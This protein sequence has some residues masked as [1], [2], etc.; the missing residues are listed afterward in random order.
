[1]ILFQNQIFQTLSIQQQQKPPD[2]NPPPPPL[3]PPPSP[4]LPSLLLLILPS[5][6]SLSAPPIFSSRCTACNNLKV[7]TCL[8]LTLVMFD[9]PAGT[10]QQY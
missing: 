4:P 6:P 5:S 8:G 1:M 2:P 10:K 7:N 9:E 3:P